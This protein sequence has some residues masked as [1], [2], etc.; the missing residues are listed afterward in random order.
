MASFPIS[1]EV[2]PAS[3]VVFTWNGTTRAT[4]GDAERGLDRADRRGSVHLRC[5]FGLLRAGTRNGRSSTS[6][7]SPGKKRWAARRRTAMLILSPRAV[8][9]LEAYAPP[10]TL[11]DKSFG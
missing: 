6:S 3:D 5:H 8:E 1:P 11:T 10:R 4:R 7:P 9:R 2:D